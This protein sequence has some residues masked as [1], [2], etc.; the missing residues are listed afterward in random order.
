M[1]TDSKQKAAGRPVIQEVLPK[2]GL[3]VSE[4]GILN[5]VGTACAWVPKMSRG[6]VRVRAASCGLQCRDT[7]RRCCASPSCCP[8]SR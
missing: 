2:N 3:V 8:S 7:L 6:R 5:E 4:K 1:P